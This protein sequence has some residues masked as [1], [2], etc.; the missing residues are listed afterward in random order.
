MVRMHNMGAKEGD[1]VVFQSE[2]GS[3]S[4]KLQ[5]KLGPGDDLRYEPCD[6]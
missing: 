4:R 6:A 3:W 2:D 1:I 5:V